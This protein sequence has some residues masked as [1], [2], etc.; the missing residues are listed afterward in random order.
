MTSCDLDI[1]LSQTFTAV[2]PVYLAN[3]ENKFNRV[4]LY[5]GYVPT[6]HP[7]LVAAIDAVAPID[8]PAMVFSGEK[9]TWFAPL[10]PEQAS[11][12]AN[13]VQVHSSNAGHEL[14][15]S[16][17]WTFQEIIEFIRARL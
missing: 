10:A 5:C 7:G 8:T 2:I 9:D 13:P 11:K 16:N 14:P 6:T 17:D 3:T 15:Y 4:M 1:T 12:F